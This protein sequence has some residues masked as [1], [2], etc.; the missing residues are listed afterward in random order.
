MI[1]LLLIFSIFTITALPALADIQNCITS[2]IVDTFWA[3]DFNTLPDSCKIPLKANYNKKHTETKTYICDKIKYTC[4]KD[5]LPTECAPCAMDLLIEPERNK[6]VTAYRKIACD[7]KNNDTFQLMNPTNTEKEN[8]ID[9]ACKQIFPNDTAP[10]TATSTSSDAA[11]RVESQS[12]ASSAKTMTVSGTVLDEKNQPLPGA[13]IY[14]PGS[15]TGTATDIDGKFELKKCTGTQIK[16][17]PNAKKTGIQ[18]GTNN[19]IATECKCGYKL[20]ADKCV[21]WMENEPCSADTKPALP[22]NAKSAIM[23]CDGEKAYCEISDCNDGY[24][25]SE[26]KKSC[27]STRGDDCDATT[28]DKNATAGT[29][30]KVKGKMVCVITDCARGFK[31]NKDGTKCVAGELSEADSQAKIDELRDNAQKMKDKEQ[32]TANK[33]LGAAGI[34]ATGIGGMQLASAMAEQN[35]DADAER[36]M[37]AYLA[38]FHCNYGNTKNIAGGERDVELPGGN[39]LIN[40]YSEYVNLANDLKTRKTALDMRPGIESES[41]LDAATSGLYDDD[42]IGKTSGAYTSLARA[43]MDPTGADAAAWAAQK[44]ETADKKKTGIITAG[45]GA[46]GSLAGNL[47]LNSGKDK[48]NKVDEILNKYDKKKQLL[49]ELES[50]V[51][52]IPPQTAPCPNDTLGTAHP[53]CTC[54]APNKIYNPNAH[55]CEACIGDQIVKDGLC[56]CPTDKPLWDTQISQ[57]IAKPTTCTPQCNP[58]EGSHLIVQYDTCAC[59]CVDGYTYENDECKCEGDNKQVGAD[60]TCQTIETTT[61]VERISTLTTNTVENATLPAG[62]LFKI[63]SYELVDEAQQA[64]TKFITGLSKENYQD[65]E[66]TV[67][68]YTDPMGGLQTNKTLSQNRA[69]AVQE[70]INSLLQNETNKKAIKSVTANGYGES[71]CTCGAGKSETDTDGQINGIQINYGDPEYSACFKQNNKHPLKGNARYAPCRR[72][73]ITADCKQITTVIQQQ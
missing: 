4:N 22:G 68:G 30:K 42:A 31:P 73:E 59:T 23:K 10:T 35:A 12:N 58:T 15:T 40:L 51:A 52:A 56:T 18:K 20:D 27:V 14:I 9:Q 19:C 16:E 55:A 61:I 72:V 66:I 36:A 39:E 71:N 26:D 70:H 29:I 3:Y 57:C 43:L 13:A 32:S 28:V 21:K 53:N 67:N 44:E 62:S 38:T 34:G 46:A 7:A 60:G 25:V 8:W 5:K 49:D 24:K 69:K 41:I 63:G 50:N 37:R 1:K 17:H 6:L 33:L 11:P 64:L 54:K 45:I 2:E 48:Q 65:C 47:A